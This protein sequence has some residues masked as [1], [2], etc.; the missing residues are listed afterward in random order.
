MKAT[1]DELKLPNGAS[2][3]NLLSPMVVA[4]AGVFILLVAATLIAALL[5]RSNNEST[6]QRNLEIAVDAAMESINVELTKGISQLK[7]IQGFFNAS[8]FVTREEFDIFVAR[9]LEEP[10]GIQALEWI[11]RVPA[12]QKAQFINSVRQE[13]FEGFTIHPETQFQEFFPVRYLAPFA[14]NTAALGFD[15]YS[16]EVR[17]AALVKAGETGELAITDPI[18]LVQETGSQLAFLAYAPVYYS[19]DIP[20]PPH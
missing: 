5:V 13:G 14:G 17:R 7:A 9:F 16:E 15:L 2:A 20:P 8:E 1:T 3:G 19:K 18:T 6:S 10:H 11:P 12:S 4:I